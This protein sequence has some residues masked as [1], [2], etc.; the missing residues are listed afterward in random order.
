MTVSQLRQRLEAL[1][2]D[3]YG[4]APHAIDVGV[5]RRVSGALD[6]PEGASE[7][8]ARVAIGLRA[9]RESGINPLDGF[10]LTD[11]AVT[12]EVEYQRTEAGEDLVEG[13]SELLG[14]G[15]DDAIGDRMSLD[16]HTIETAFCWHE[17]WADLDP[18]VWSITRAGQPDTSFDGPIA[19]LTLSFV[20][21]E[22]TTQP[23][24]YGP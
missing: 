18:H 21:S 1:L 17:H 6:T 23:G 3:G 15:T 7:R 10:A 20:V 13:Y 4:N 19:R 12:V 11:R 5:F 14:A 22:R 8:R 2:F 16:Q 24:S 9:P